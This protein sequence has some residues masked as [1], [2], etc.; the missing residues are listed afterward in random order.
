MGRFDKDEDDMNPRKLMNEVRDIMETYNPAQFVSIT[1]TV[2]PGEAEALMTL[3]ENL[4]GGKPSDSASEPSGGA[5]F[6]VSHP[7]DRK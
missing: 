5:P 2:T 7:E 4:R 6:D 3:L 1:M